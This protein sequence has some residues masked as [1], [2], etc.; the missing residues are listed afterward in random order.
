MSFDFTIFHRFL[1]FLINYLLQK[2]RYN[3]IRIDSLRV[4]LL[5]CPQ[6][7]CERYSR[8]H[9]CLHSDSEVHK[10][11]IMGPTPYEK[12]GDVVGSWLDSWSSWERCRSWWISFQASCQFWQTASRWLV[13]RFDWEADRA[14]ASEPDSWPAVGLHLVSYSIDQ[15]Q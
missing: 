8:R 10:A 12:W 13:F 14:A 1:L 2:Q 11:D 3:S 6:H 7:V 5:S 15:R 9:L 4:L